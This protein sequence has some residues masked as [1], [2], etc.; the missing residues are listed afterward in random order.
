[1]QKIGPEERAGIYV[2]MDGRTIAGPTGPK[3]YAH[4][5]DGG[6]SWIVPY[7]AGAY[8]LAAQVDP[9]ITPERFRSLAM[10]TGRTIQTSVKGQS[11]SLGPILD[12][13][14]LIQAL[15]KKKA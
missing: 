2:P 4:Y 15:R 14:A 1:M 8:A 3:E 6:L 5:G 10:K 9:G 13:P 11:V 12:M 7:M